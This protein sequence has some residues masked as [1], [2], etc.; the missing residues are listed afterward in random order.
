[1]EKKEIDKL[2]K[3][4]PIETRVGVAIQAYFINEYGGNFFIRLDENGNDIQEDVD[5]AK[6]IYDKAKPLIKIVL[7]EIKEWKE[8]GSP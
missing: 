3:E 8:D 6:K 1:M 7:D 2:L 5:T 4:I